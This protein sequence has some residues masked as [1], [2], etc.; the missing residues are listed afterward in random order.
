M[1]RLEQML[2]DELVPNDNKSLFFAGAENKLQ[3]I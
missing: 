1:Q 2:L 3:N